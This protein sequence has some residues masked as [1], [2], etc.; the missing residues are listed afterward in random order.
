MPH[1]VVVMSVSEAIWD[2]LKIVVI[3][4]FIKLALGAVVVLLTIG[5]LLSL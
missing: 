5:W 1:E 4:V 3:D 2:T